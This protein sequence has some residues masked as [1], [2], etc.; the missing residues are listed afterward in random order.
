V[1]GVSEFRRRLQRAAKQSF[2]LA[3][4]HPEQLAAMEQVLEGH[5]VM[6]VLPTGADKSA[7]YQVPALLLPGVAVIVSPLLALQADQLLAINESAA[8]AVAGPA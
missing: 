1:P 3:Q 8:P 7:I 2:G 5:D 4:L 6:A